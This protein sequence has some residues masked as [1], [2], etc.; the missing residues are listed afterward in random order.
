MITRVSASDP[1]FKDFSLKP[2]FNLCVATKSK[3]AT[4]R[5]ST[6]TLG[7]SS[8][9]RLLHFA[10][11]AKPRK[12]VGIPNVS[13]LDGWV[14]RYE[15]SVGGH[16]LIVERGARSS[17]VVVHGAPPAWGRRELDGSI[18]L[19][20]AE[21][22]KLLGRH[23]YGL[24]DGAG[25]P[26]FRQLIDYS[27]RYESKHFADPFSILS[28][29]QAVS[30]SA[31]AWLLG[32]PWN[33]PYEQQQIKA[34][35]KELAPFKQTRNRT[36]F[37]GISMSR[38]ELEAERARLLERIETLENERGRYESKQQHIELSERASALTSEF[39]RLS[40]EHQA[41]KELLA[42][43]EEAVREIQP[44]AAAAQVK[45]LYDEANIW[46]PQPMTKQVQ[47]VEAFHNKLVLH[48]RDFLKQEIA[49]L[50][51]KQTERQLR[52]TAI[53][54]ERAP[55]LSI[56]NEDEA[57][58]QYAQLAVELEE[59][60]KNVAGINTQ[61]D[62]LRTANEEELRLK[63]QLQNLDER[64]LIVHD[65]YAAAR[66]HAQRLFSGFVKSMF[67]EEGRLLIDLQTPSYRIEPQIPS[68]AAGG[69]GGVNKLSIACADLT[70]ARLLHER[71]TGPGL[72]VHDSH[73]FDAMDA[74]QLAGTLNAAWQE[75]SSLGYTYL[76]L[77]NQD[78]LEAAR[79]YIAIAGLDD[80][81]RLHL[82]D[83][84]SDGGLFG[85]RF[86]RR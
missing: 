84:H 45:A 85:F 24:H 12:N 47:D 50:N 75:S 78:Q 31:S 27:L 69:V 53:D 38:A 1:R 36:S 73:V 79:A 81:V 66:E 59:L 25:E 83:H 37:L 52:M 71:G 2:G 70:I 48:R 86:G 29:S 5:D 68:L 7:K 44:V 51:R 39:N 62:V 72:L 22:T 19:K 16:N 61:L 13:A 18:R 41:D 57:V 65:E 3:E 28:G 15:M 34:R 60:K 63:G 74:R 67:V 82:T 42:H 49:T 9:M 54:R 17:D 20:S 21:W 4:A 56:L 80:Y 33:L 43:Y 76:A 40:A 58:P 11:G 23:V 64:A 32:L 35:I 14:F 46:L 55:I 30:T 26:T 77:L 6:N 8:A 10:L